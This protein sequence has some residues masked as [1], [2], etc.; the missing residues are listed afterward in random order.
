MSEENIID[1]NL[2]ELV[3][4]SANVLDQ[5]FINAPKDKAKL[6][7]KNMK[8][9]NK[10]SLGQITINNSIVAPVDITLDYSEFRGPGFNFDVFIAALRSILGQ[11]SEKFRAKAELNILS[12][13]D[14][15]QL[16]HLPGIVNINNQFNVMVLAIALGTLDKITISLMFVDP[17][18]YDALKP[19]ETTAS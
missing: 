7:F 17:D 5:L 12:S 13:D 16:I 8:N 18:Q 6:T 14:N 1:L 2:M 11:L 10:Q 3:N 15:T 4:M 19:R 9:G